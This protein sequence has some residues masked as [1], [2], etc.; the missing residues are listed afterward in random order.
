MAI[1][2]YPNR[3]QRG[4]ISA[5]EQQMRRGVKYV[6]SGGGNIASTAL[7]DVISP[8]RDWTMQSILF[9]F[10][11][12]TS[13][14][15]SVTAKNGRRVVEKFNDYLWFHVEGTNPQRITLSP[16]FY[17]GTELAAE[18]QTQLD[19]N[20]AYVTAGITFTV[21]YSNAT[22]TFEVTP[23]SSTIKYLDVNTQQTIQI[24]DS[25]AGHL[26]GLNATSVFASSAASDTNVA[27]L[28]DT[29]GIVSETGSSVLTYYSDTA[30]SLTVD[31][32]LAI[33]TS[34]ATIDVTYTMAYTLDY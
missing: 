30:R 23:S 20:A 8:E 2:Y 3:S 7:T 5:I 14:D 15:F 16:G 10:S 31:Q 12:A 28:D 4:S 32:A 6:A 27:G 34:T 26:F 33:N 17:T 19:A 29:T 11:G 18:L 25:I 9:N 1:K 13:R 22:G 21:T 24:K